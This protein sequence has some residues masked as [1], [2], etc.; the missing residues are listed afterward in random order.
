MERAPTEDVPVDLDHQIDAL[1]VEIQ[2]K[3]VLLDRL[4]KLAGSPTPASTRRTISLPKE[5]IE[6]RKEFTEWKNAIRDRAVDD[7]FEILTES[8]LSRLA[9]LLQIPAKNID[10]LGTM[11]VRRLSEEIDHNSSERIASRRPRATREEVI[12]AVKTGRAFVR[13]LE[14]SPALSRDTLI[15]LVERFVSRHA[16]RRG[17]RPEIA[18]CKRFAR[19]AREFIDGTLILGG[20]PTLRYKQGSGT[21]PKALAELRPLFPSGFIPDNLPLKTLDDWLQEAKRGLRKMPPEALDEWL[22]EWLQDVSDVYVYRCKW[23][24]VTGADGARCSRRA[25][26]GPSG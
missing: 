13:A 10:H 3:T 23:R 7:A 1:R 12:R 20:K 26:V 6:W 17:R 5:F 11:L 22:D 8:R 9:S 24:P 15:I 21:V 18:D 14:S 2:E 19:F 25:E 16:S 4:Q